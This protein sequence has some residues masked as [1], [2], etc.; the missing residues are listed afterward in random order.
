MS[1]AAAIQSLHDVNPDAVRLAESVSFAAMIDRA[2]LRAARLAL[3]PPVDAGAEADLWFSALVQSRTADGIVFHPEAADALRQRMTAQQVEDVWNLTSDTHAWLA[4]SLRLEER[5]AYL[6]VSKKPTASEDLATCLRSVLAAM[7]SGERAGLAQWAVRALAMFPSRVQALP[8][9]RMLETGTRMRLGDAMAASSADEPLPAWMTWLAPA[10]LGTISLD[11][12]L[13]DGELEIRT[14]T[15]DLP[16]K[17]PKTN[18]LILEVSW[19]NDSRLQHTRQITFRDKITVPVGSRELT[20]RTITGEEFDLHE[21]GLGTSR[22]REAIVDFSREMQRHVEVVGR[23]QEIQDVLDLTES[24]GNI[25]ITGRRGLGK[26][27]FLCELIREAERRGIPTAAHFFRFGDLRLESI[28]AAERSLIAQIAVRFGLAERVLDLRLM[29]VLRGLPAGKRVLVVVDDVDEARDSNRERVSGTLYEAFERL[30]AGIA[31]IASVTKERN[32]AWRTHGLRPAGDSTPN[33][34]IPSGNYAKNELIAQLNIYSFSADVAGIR[35]LLNVYAAE[36]RQVVSFGAVAL[37]PLSIQ[38]R[39]PNSSDTFLRVE[40]DEFRILNDVARKLVIEALGPEGVTEAHRVLVDRLEQNRHLGS[41]ERYYLTNA[42][43]HLVEAREMHA[44]R[45]LAMRVEFMIAKIE[46]FGVRALSSDFRMLEHTL[47]TNLVMSALNDYE[48]ELEAS[49][50]DLASILHTATLSEDLPPPHLPLRP[51]II[52]KVDTKVRRPRKHDGPIRG[53]RLIMDADGNSTLATWSDDGTV[54]MWSVSSG[55]LIDML[56]VGAPVTALA[57]RYPYAITADAMGFLQL[58]TSAP[59][60]IAIRVNAHDRAIDGMLF[61]PTN[62]LIVTW[63]GSDPIRLWLL[64]QAGGTIESLGELRGHS[65][66]VVGC[67]LTVE[68]QLLVSASRGGTCRLWSISSKLELDSASLWGATGMAFHWD[69]ASRFILTGKRTL[70]VV[71]VTQSSLSVASRSIDTGHELPVTGVAVS[72]DGK[73]VATWSD[74]QTIRL[75]DVPTMSGPRHILRGHRAAIT[76]CQFEGRGLISTDAEGIA[77]VWDRERG[78]IVSRLDRPTRAIRTIAI[79]GESIFI[80]G[81]DGVV[82]GWSVVG[83][84]FIDDFSEPVGRI[85]ECVVLPG[86]DLPVLISDGETGIRTGSFESI[87][88]MPEPIL[89]TSRDDVFVCA[90]NASTATYFTAGQSR[91]IPLPDVPDIAACAVT[92][93]SYFAI[94]TRDGRQFA[95]GPE[96]YWQELVDDSPTTHLAFA[97]RPF[98]V[99]TSVDGTISIWDLGRGERLHRLDAHRSRILALAALENTA[100]TGS[101]DGTL[102]IWDL[103]TGSAQTIEAAHVGPVTGLWM[104]GNIVV[105][106][107]LDRTIRVF[108]SRIAKELTVCR[109]HRDRITGVAIAMTDEVLYSCSDDR[110]IRQWDIETG[111]QKAIVYGTAPFRCISWRDGKL[112]AGDDAGN[113]WTVKASTPEPSPRRLIYLSFAR[114]DRSQNEFAQVLAGDLRRFGIQLAN[115]LFSLPTPQDMERATVVVVIVPKEHDF[116]IQSDIDMA[117]RLGKPIIPISLEKRSMMRFTL[118]LGNRQPIVMGDPKYYQAGLIQ[119]SDAILKAFT[120]SA[121]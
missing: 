28:D 47:L 40:G 75:W 90:T 68:G 2:F 87:L 36:L 17:L 106:A 35:G 32:R 33:E 89:A 22:L 55:E 39:G 81:D 102:R 101:A 18:P 78:E 71:Q 67:G 98:L 59:N 91:L 72:R 94:A 5:I 8:E 25:A 24:T 77:I 51:Q 44:A 16:V 46:M 45:E 80:G 13:R 97:A 34:T 57:M 21:T 76:A 4:P 100:V 118:G 70:D 29:E 66:A 114:R 117:S 37:Q 113:L 109:G 82:L 73:F 79:D 41:V 43:W 30:P 56:S 111:E 105:S 6:S 23:E 19:R 54:R 7:V 49:P 85:D 93:N 26:T 38:I 119:L 104:E 60:A 95:V 96:F 103:R 63:A 99:S 108:D 62:N 31:V 9:A 27:A 74:D 88:L 86:D 12:E 14:T 61:N 10:S 110:T 120:A 20:L 116:S 42:V 112:A 15:Q 115:N 65:S 53:S 48:S 84:P 107:S 58:W 52:R 11:L 1:I 64:N 121:S 69:A 50:R 3:A 92:D 83:G